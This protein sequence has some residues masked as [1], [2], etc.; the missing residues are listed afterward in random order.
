MSTLR[1]QIDAL[2]AELGGHGLGGVP[3]AMLKSV[4]LPQLRLLKEEQHAAV[5]AAV[6]EIVTVL[7]RV[8]ELD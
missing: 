5:T 1:E 6:T 7:R 3:G 8:F 2:E 4:V